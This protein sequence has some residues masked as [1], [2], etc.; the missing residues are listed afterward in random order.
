MSHS[1]AEDSAIPSYEKASRIRQ[2]NTLNT[3]KPAIAA[4]IKV[5]VTC[6]EEGKKQR[7]QPDFNELFNNI[8]AEM[9]DPQMIF[10]RSHL[11]DDHTDRTGGKRNKS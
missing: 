2:E 5:A 7:Q 3:W 4:M 11:P 10:F 1:V 9:T 6:G 8:D